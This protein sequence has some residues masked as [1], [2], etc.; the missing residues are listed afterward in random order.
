MSENDNGKHVEYQTS[1]A[2]ECKE[3]CSK[4]LLETSEPYRNMLVQD[5]ELLYHYTDA[6]GLVGNSPYAAS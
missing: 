1:K 5:D 6:Q 2:N 3:W 4:I